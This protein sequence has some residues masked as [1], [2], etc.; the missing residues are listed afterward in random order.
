MVSEASFNAYQFIHESGII[1]KKPIPDSL[2]Q[3]P[4]RLTVRLHFNGERP[5]KSSAA[6]K[7]IRTAYLLALSKLVKNYRLKLIKLKHIRPEASVSIYTNKNRIN[8]DEFTVSDEILK[9]GA[10]AISVVH[11]D[12]SNLILAPLDYLPRKLTAKNLLKQ[13]KTISMYSYT[14]T[15]WATS[16]NSENK[17]SP[18]KLNGTLAPRERLS[19]QAINKSIINAAA[20]LVRGQKLSGQFNYEY[21][22][23]S[24]ESSENYNIVRHAGVTWAILRLYNSTEREELLKAGIKGI[25]FLLRN[26]KVHKPNNKTAFVS[27]ESRS[28]LGATALSILALMELPYHLRNKTI[29][30]KARALGFGLEHLMSTDGRF[31]LS[32]KEK[33]EH[34]LRNKP[35]PFFPGESLLA[36][37]T[38]WKEDSNY[39]EESTLLTANR[40]A[41]NFKSYNSKCHWSVQGLALAGKLDNSRFLLTTSF[42]MATLLTE[43]QYK[44]LDG[45]NAGGWPSS[46]RAPTACSAACRLEALGPAIE[47]G[48]RL[49]KDCTI[50]RNRMLKGA[51]FIISQQITKAE[52]FFLPYP[53]KTSGGIRMFPQDLTIRMDVNQHSIAALL[54]T[55]NL[56]KASPYLLDVI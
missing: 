39:W 11:S 34:S 27:P 12:G 49:G 35:V 33:Q 20:Y 21:Y 3:G 46:A 6:G 17:Q 43:N 50:L 55:S 51:E 5:I 8:P 31:F 14:Q 36:L 44:D 15:T 4:A 28:V 26:I 13:R 47:A 24:D 18:F 25:K 42:E 9:T 16:V 41:Q 19:L 10:K 7:T 1:L 37:A 52:A 22:P 29:V 54:N 40:Q 45:I 30:S 53:A 23:W 48:V 56:L 2:N 32:L 38:L